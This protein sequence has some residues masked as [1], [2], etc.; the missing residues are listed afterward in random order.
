[1]ALSPFSNPHK[2]P[3]AQ[4]IGLAVAASILARHQGNLRYDGQYPSN[5]WVIQLPK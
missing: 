2:K 1:M 4:R 5:R 3:Q